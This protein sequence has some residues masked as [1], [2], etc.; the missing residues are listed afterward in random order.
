MLAATAGSF[1]ADSSAAAA[2]SPQTVTESRCVSVVVAIRS[3]ICADGELCKVE[4]VE[5]VWVSPRAISSPLETLY[6]RERRGFILSYVQ[7]AIKI[8]LTQHCRAKSILCVSILSRNR[9]YSVHN[10]IQ[11]SF[12]SVSNL[13]DCQIQ[14]YIFK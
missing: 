1:W 6:Q 14:I 9:P 10:C 11:I 13:E 3:S 5:G 2:A 4:A 7:T 8:I 12:L